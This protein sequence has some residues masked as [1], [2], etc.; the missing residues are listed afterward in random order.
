[1]VDCLHYFGTLY[2]AALL[3]NPWN[4]W[5]SCND[6]EILR[7]KITIKTGQPFFF[8]K[9]GDFIYILFY[10]LLLKK[11]VD[12]LYEWLNKLNLKFKIILT[13]TMHVNMFKLNYSNLKMLLGI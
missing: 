12:F 2:W 8:N 13:L 4:L 5:A 9:G 1:M 6:L 10:F 7:L 3:L 11:K